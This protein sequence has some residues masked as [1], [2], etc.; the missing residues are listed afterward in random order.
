MKKNF[1]LNRK[2][3]CHRNRKCYCHIMHVHRTLVTATLLCLSM[4][5]SNLAQAAVCDVDTDGDV[6]RLDISLIISARDSPADG[7]RD[8][9]DADGDGN[10]TVFDARTC[11]RRCNLKGCAIVDPAPPPRAEDAGQPDEPDATPVQKPV[12]DTSKPGKATTGQLGTVIQGRTKVSG[13]EWKVKRGD[14]LYA[15]GRAVFPGD[16]D[17]QTRLRQDIMKLNPSVFANGAN[18][19]A[20]GT[21]LKLPDYVVSKSAPSKIAVPAQVPAPESDTVT[22]GPASQPAAKVESEP[23]SQVK[24]E[25]STVKGQSVF[26]LLGTESNFLVSLGYSYGGD[27]LVYEDGSYDPAGASAHLRLGNEQMY[28]NG[29]GYRIALGL[30]Y[31]LANDSDNTSLRDNYLQLAYQ[32]RANPFVYGIGAVFHN[33]ATVKGDS[34]INYDAANGVVVY[35][36]N[37]GSGDLAGWGLS[38][39]SLDIEDEDTSESFDASRAELYYSWRF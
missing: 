15:I 3:Y 19:M 2:R 36:E 25:P 1:H 10:I 18:N 23:E 6:D 5:F 14:T 20:V 28:Q 27:K 39:T 37:V 31:G 8:P 9:R 26:S 22:P 38:Y 12:K 16:A 32:Y 7:S 24:I 33:G 21:V 4:G 34:T 11:I 29:G 35:L 30:Q 17:K 13:T